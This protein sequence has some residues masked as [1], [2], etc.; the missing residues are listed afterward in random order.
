MLLGR[1]EDSF[2]RIPDLLD[3]LT[4]DPW[5]LDSSGS[6]REAAARTLGEGAHSEG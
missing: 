3:Q 4:Q 2:G 6:E 1:C 5:I